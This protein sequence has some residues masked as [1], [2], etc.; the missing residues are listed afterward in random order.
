VAPPWMWTAAALAAG[1]A[2][3]A[4]LAGSP[5]AAAG[6]YG[7]AAAAAAGLVTRWHLRRAGG[8]GP[9]ATLRRALRC[10][11]ERLALSG[12]MLAAGFAAFGLEPPA[13]LAGFL[14]GVAGATAGGYSSLAAGR[15]RWR[16]ASSP[17][18]STSSTTS[19]T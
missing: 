15:H 6:A 2:A 5:G 14:L 9:A 17:R 11:I 16:P 8:L 12:G 7:A 3:G 13:L 10:E 1:A 18:A 19:R 4:A